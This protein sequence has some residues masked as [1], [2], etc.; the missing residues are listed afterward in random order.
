LRVI[1]EGTP[2]FWLTQA[3]HVGIGAPSWGLKG[4]IVIAIWSVAMA[5]VA[6]WAYRRDT[7]KV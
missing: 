2:S 4:C 6:G 7:K 3:S 1:G 5:A